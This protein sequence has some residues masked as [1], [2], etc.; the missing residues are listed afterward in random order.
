MRLKRVPTFL[1]ALFY[2]IFYIFMLGIPFADWGEIIVGSGPDPYQYIWNADVFATQIKNGQNPFFTQK[3]FYPEGASLLMHTY[4]PIIGILNLIVNNPY[5]SCNIALLLSF[6]LSGLGAF[7]LAS[8][9]IRDGW[10]AF[11]AGFIFAFSPFKTAHL[12]EH[13]HLLLTAHVPFYVWAVFRFFPKGTI[14]LNTQT[15]KKALVLLAIGIVSLWSDYYTTFYLILF[16]A[17]YFLFFPLQKWWI[18]NPFKFR[19][20]IVIFTVIGVHF[21]MEAFYLHPK[22]DDKG[23]IYNSSDI[24]ALVIPA[25]NQ[26]ISQNVDFFQKM[27]KKMHFKGPNEQVVFVGYTLMLLLILLFFQKKTSVPTAFWPMT[28]LCIFFLIISFP[29]V[30]WMGHTLFYTPLSWFHLVPFF[31]HI[32]NPSR[33]IMMFYLFLPMV[34]FVWFEAI[35]WK[36]TWVKKSIPIFIALLVIIEFTP[37]SFANIKKVDIPSHYRA[38]K[39][40]PEVKTIWHIPTGA[41]DGFRLEGVFDIRNLQQQME[42][43][44]NLIGGYISRVDEKTFEYFKNNSILQFANDSLASQPMF[45]ETSL[46]KF[47]NHHQI[48]VIIFNQKNLQGQL[49]IDSFLTQHVS[50]IIRSDREKIVYLNRLNF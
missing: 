48:N 28:F 21:M 20:W 17:V 31:N 50:K 7:L 16:T 29:K 42:H 25:E 33:A 26:A 10:L 5:L 43:Q 6:V 44:K 32:R 39:D 19:N 15:V 14:L 45:N 30:K 4:T 2:A 47:L 18:N 23:A 9:W 35:Q 49:L 40:D 36:R 12:M 46:K 27:R 13:Y 3:F 24:L 1:A 38:F 11:L 37:K 22:T 41:I 34:L 8:L